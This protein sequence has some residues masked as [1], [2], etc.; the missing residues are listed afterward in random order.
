MTVS[1]FERAMAVV[2]LFIVA[3]TSLGVLVFDII[4]GTTVQYYIL[5]ILYT[6]ITSAATVAGIQISSVAAIRNGNTAAGIAADAMNKGIEVGTKLASG[7]GNGNG[8]KP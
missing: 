4:S 2:F 5:V 3:L 7:N 8:S 6:A 1:P